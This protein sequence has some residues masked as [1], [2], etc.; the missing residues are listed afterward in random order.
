MRE[1]F[2][3]VNKW[4]IR[5]GSL[6]SNDSVGRAGAFIIPLTQEKNAKVA[7]VIAIDGRDT[8]WEHVSVYVQY[9]ASKGKIR[10]RTPNWGEM[11]FIKNSFWDEEECVV[12]YHPARSQYVNNHPFVLHMWKPNGQEMPVPPAMLVGVVI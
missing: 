4:R 5:K 7:M 12:Q 1:T 8:G 10:R 2:E 11:C 3:H 9:Q 6:A